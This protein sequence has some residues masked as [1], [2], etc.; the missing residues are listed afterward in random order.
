MMSTESDSSSDKWWI[1]LW[2]TEEISRMGYLGEVLVGR[3]SK[4]FH[5][6]EGKDLRWLSMDNIAR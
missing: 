5:W 3:I 2:K 6:D 1:S 4:T